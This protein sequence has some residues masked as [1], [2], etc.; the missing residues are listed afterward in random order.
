MK[1]LIK[2]FLCK[3]FK[4]KYSGTKTTVMFNTPIDFIECKRCNIHH[5]IRTYEKY[6]S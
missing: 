5:I 1:K 2:R 3:I 6:G 4:H